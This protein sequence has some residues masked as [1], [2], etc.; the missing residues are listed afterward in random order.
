MKKLLLLFLLIS[1][2]LHAE[3]ELPIPINPEDMVAKNVDIEGEAPRSSERTIDINERVKEI[4]D[5]ADGYMEDGKFAKAIAWYT[6]AIKLKDDSY[7]HIYRGMAYEYDNKRTKALEDYRTAYKLD[8]KNKTALYNIAVVY[9]KLGKKKLAIGVLD[10]ALAIDKN[11][12]RAKRL[13][14]KLEG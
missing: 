4:L 3:E 11:F 9:T 13:K 5:M 8:N 14:Q 10:K 1:A 12:K 6:K 2:L 7:T